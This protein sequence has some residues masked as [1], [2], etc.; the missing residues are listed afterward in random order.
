MRVSTSSGSI[1]ITAEARDDVEVVASGLV[2]RRPSTRQDPIDVRRSDTVEVRCPAGS[3]VM[4]GTH[5]GSVR[6]K[7]AFGDVRV[8]SHSGS[9]SVGEVASADLRT[10]S[11]DV[12]VAGCDG[13]CR[14]AVKSGSVRIGRSGD[15]EVGG[16]S[17]TVRVSGLNARVRT[18]SGTVD[19]HVGG[20]AT[21]ETVSGSITVSLPVHVHPRIEM[22]AKRA[23]I[24][25]TEGEDC[26]LSVR[27]VSGSVT[28]RPR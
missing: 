13:V 3:D 7:G 26:D 17:G 5:S 27:S 12:E 20:D 24:E 10:R 4:A 28:V 1:T 14:V 25:V 21:V 8:T 22:R 23:R 16:V 15:A 2:E 11:G 9:L 6:L 18:V 19:L